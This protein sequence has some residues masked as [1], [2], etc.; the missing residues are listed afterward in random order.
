[1]FF[2]IVDFNKCCSERDVY[3]FGR[4]GIPVVYFRCTSCGFLFT[5]FFDSWSPEDFGRFVY[6]DDYIR[7]DG[8]YT[9]PRPLRE[10]EAMA[11]RLANYRNLRILDYGSGSGLFAS[12]LRNRG[13]AHVTSYDPF[14][15]PERPQGTFELITCFEVLEHTTNPHA[16]LADIA[17]LLDPGGCVIFST[18]VQPESI[19]ALRCSWWYVAPRNG[20][21][22]IYTLQSLA[23]LG[24]KLNLVLHAGDM[25][26]AFAG[27]AAS[28]SMRK[29]LDGIGPARLFHNLA[30]PGRS[31]TVP[32]EQAKCWHA[33]EGSPG[34]M[35]RWTKEAEIPWRLQ[36]GKL[37]PGN[38]TIRMDVVNE[39][40]PGFIDGC[41]LRVG[42]KDIPFRREGASL[43]ASFTLK[44]ASEPLVTLVTPPLSRPSELRGVDDT[45][46]LGVAVSSRA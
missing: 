33:V 23:T 13:F 38:I 24:A 32:A 6:N 29:L 36:P 46:L 11:T 25:S 35:F 41:I 10:A 4:A 17:G 1:M 40:E 21:A 30:A 31:D 34:A 44:A 16:T 19:N 15:S 27:P 18:G 22:S 28:I 14:S 26:T 3:Q 43:V 12:H 2:D 7:V 37:P 8:E 39:I 9:G 20:H 5:K 42:K 45:R